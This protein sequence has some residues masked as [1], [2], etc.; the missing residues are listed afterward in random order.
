MKIPEFN[1]GMSKSVQKVITKDDTAL[2]F[3]S[4]ALKNLLATPTL[5]ALM[6][7]AA[8]KTVD[9][10]LPEG[11]ITIGKRTEIEHEHPTQE[12]MT[13]TVT[14]K[15]I[16]V[17]GSVLSFEI[18]AFD[19]LGR[20]GVGYHKRQIVKHSILMKKV[21]ERLGIIESRP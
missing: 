18:T 6:I 11:Y 4:G 19:E 1:I 8:V 12:G 14:A 17:V 13:V 16:E 7:E 15:L 10:L 2:N 20:I 3:G 21:E 5:I 9:P